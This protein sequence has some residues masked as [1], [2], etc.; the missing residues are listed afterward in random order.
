MVLRKSRW[1]GCQDVEDV[2]YQCLAVTS[3]DI[4]S[5]GCEASE[6]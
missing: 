6:V 5:A 2:L 3:A 4:Y 1:V